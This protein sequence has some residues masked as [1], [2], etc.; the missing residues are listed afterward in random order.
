MV[1]QLVLGVV[2]VHGIAMAIYYFG[3][4][5][6]AAPKSRTIFVGVWTFAT[7]ITVAVLLR[8]VRLVRNASRTR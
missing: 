6:Q 4:I 5:E 8:R 2:I 3:G 1:L 7:A